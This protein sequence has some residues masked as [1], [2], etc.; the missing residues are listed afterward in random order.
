[1]LLSQFCIINITNTFA[2]K[3]SGILLTAFLLNASA[4]HVKV[5]QQDMQSGGAIIVHETDH[6]Q[7]HC[8]KE[9]TIDKGGPDKQ[10]WLLD[11]VAVTRYI[12][13]WP[14]LCL[15]SVC[16]YIPDLLPL[17]S[18]LIDEMKINQDQHPLTEKRFHFEQPGFLEGMIGES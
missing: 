18:N 16:H 11:P 7:P 4:I 15:A 10:N 5:S 6:M 8:D 1:M 3:L 14:L 12:H 17:E 2:M 13:F 9:C